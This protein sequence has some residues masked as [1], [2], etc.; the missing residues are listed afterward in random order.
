M[1]LWQIALAVFIVAWGL[2]AAGTY[3][4]MRH[5]SAV[6]GEISRRWSDGFLGAGNA[7]SRLGSGVILLLVVSP[8][9][10]VRR[11]MIMKG[12]SIFARFARLREVEGKALDELPTSP[13]FTHK[14]E[15]GALS[16]AMQ[17]IEKASAPKGG[18]DS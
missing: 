16:V 18:A 17:Q 14:A 9:R 6:M 7:R 1:P 12:R 8:D 10:I 11:V 4:Q 15:R 5:Y 2:Q 13:V 3:V